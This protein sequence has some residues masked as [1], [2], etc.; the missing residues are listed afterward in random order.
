[1]K[2]YRFGM[3]FFIP[4]DYHDDRTQFVENVT[5]YKGAHT[6]KAG[7]EFNRTVSSQTFVGF[8]NGRY[9]F[10]STEGFLNYLNNPN[11]VECAGGATSQTGTCRAALTDRSRHL[12]PPAGR[13]RR[14][15]GAAGG[16]AVDPS[17]GVGRLRAG[18][19]AADIR[20]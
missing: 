3:P 12:L 17:G 9:I 5:Y 10:S 2:G 8:V 18:H 11:Y 20:T 14:P 15:D 4:V 16:H 7:V 19:L 13:C 6:F 1:M